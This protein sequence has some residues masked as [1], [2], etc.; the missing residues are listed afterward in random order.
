MAGRLAFPRL[1]LWVGDDVVLYWF[2]LGA[3]IRRVSH[4]RLLRAVRVTSPAHPQGRLAPRYANLGAGKSTGNA[5]PRAAWLVTA[6][7]F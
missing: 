3:V 6:H 7:K 4:E 1:K 5:E 2:G